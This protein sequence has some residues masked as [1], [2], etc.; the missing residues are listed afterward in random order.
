MT[1]FE[2]IT[3]QRGSLVHQAG[4]WGLQSNHHKE[5]LMFVIREVC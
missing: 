3:G 5:K 2:L 4:E 1:G